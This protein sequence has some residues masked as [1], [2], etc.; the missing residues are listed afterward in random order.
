MP[1]RDPSNEG[2]RQLLDA[3]IVN[4]LVEGPLPEGVAVDSHHPA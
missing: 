1:R 2:D 4:Q 3:H